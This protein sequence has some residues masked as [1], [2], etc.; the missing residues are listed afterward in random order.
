[1][2]GVNPFSSRGRSCMELI[3][4][5]QGGGDMEVYPFSPRG[6]RYGSLSS[7]LKGGGMYVYGK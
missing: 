1:L 5:P 7:Y 6:R 3:L 4:S 2:Y